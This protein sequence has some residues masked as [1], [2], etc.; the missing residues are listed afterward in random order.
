MNYIIF[1][2]HPGDLLTT[3]KNKT[4]Y[5]TFIN[6]ES[7]KLKLNGLIKLTHQN[8]FMANIQPLSKK[9]SCQS[10]VIILDKWLAQGEIIDY[11]IKI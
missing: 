2:N 6:I 10:L 4:Y 9:I 11:Q 3:E 7:F 5:D 8:T 1:D